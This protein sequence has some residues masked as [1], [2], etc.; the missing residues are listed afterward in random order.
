MDTYG[1]RSVFC[2]LKPVSRAQVTE[3][4]S[5]SAELKTWTSDPC[6]L[7]DF[8]NQWHPNSFNFKKK[9]FKNVNFYISQTYNKNFK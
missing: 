1:Q 7:F 5:N 9:F 3:K 8:I 6:S 4:K 2:S